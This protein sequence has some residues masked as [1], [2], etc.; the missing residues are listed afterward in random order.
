M[1]R[2]FYRL[3]GTGNAMSAAG[4]SNQI[5]QPPY[6]PKAGHRIFVLSAA[7]LITEDQG[8]RQTMN[9]EAQ[10]IQTTPDTL[11]MLQSSEIDQQIATAHRFPR[12]IKKFRDTTLEMVTLTGTIARECIYALK[13]GDSIIEGP[14]ARFAEIVASAWGNCRAGARVVS[15]GMEFVTAQGVFHDLE[16]NVAITYEVQRR[17]TDK[18]GNRYKTDMIGVTANA[19]CSIALRNAIL[20]GVPKAF[21]ADTYAAARKVIAGDVRTIGSRREEAIKAFAIFGVTAEMIYKFLNVNG[22]ED[23]TI[24]HL[25][26]LSGTLTAIQEGDTTVEQQFPEAKKPAQKEKPKEKPPYDD[27]KFKKDIESW[28]GVVASGN[29]TPEEIIAMISSRNSLTPA[30]IKEIK[31]LGE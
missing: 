19:A 23:I 20:K 7:R 31:A 30:Q 12:S 24:E 29:K 5:T 14:S 26:V 8:Y 21:W 16:H 18:H 4:G 28:K 6:Q 27:A 9:T 13:R 2:D 3:L 17:I 1:P 15:E 11:S 22:K 25:V 10:E